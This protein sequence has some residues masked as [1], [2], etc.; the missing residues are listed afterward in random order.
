MKKLIEQQQSNSTFSNQP[1][2]IDDFIVNQSNEVFNDEE[3]RL[4]NEGLK[5]S[6]NPNTIPL[7]DTI[8]SIETVLKFKM[9]PVKD[10]IRRKV[11]NVWDSMNGKTR[12]VKS[13]EFEIIDNLKKRD[14]VYVKADKGNKIVVMGKPD[15]EKR[16][17]DLIDKCAYKEI[18]SNPL[19]K[20]VTKCGNL[21]KKI[22]TIFSP[23]LQRTLYV[24]NPMVAKIYMDCQK[25]IKLAIK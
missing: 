17:S 11:N 1:K 3:L 25:S 12:N 6:P 20:M 7:T 22:G 23:R 8:L 21:R 5:Y 2:L 24:P 10:D 16:M 14:C 19:T 15:Y 13:N 4:L 9:N 18:T